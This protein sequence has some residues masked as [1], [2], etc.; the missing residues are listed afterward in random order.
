[1]YP[2]V[3]EAVAHLS[4]FRSAGHGFRSLQFTAA[5]TSEE[6][7]T[8]PVVGQFCSLYHI[9]RCGWIPVVVLTDQQGG[10]AAK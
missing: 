10:P 2:L 3:G 5:K 6:H 7:F 1:M 9:A 8:V 4:I